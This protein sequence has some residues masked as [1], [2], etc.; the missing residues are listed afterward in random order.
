[1]FSQRERERAADQSR[2]EDRDALKGK[3]V[4]HRSSRNIES[5]KFGTRPKKTICAREV[6]NVMDRAVSERMKSDSAENSDF[7]GAFADAV[8][9]HPD[10][11]LL[12]ASGR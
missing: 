10:A 11:G 7:A 4:R 1:M 9:F 6:E 12:G 5:E 8:T 2:A 3:R